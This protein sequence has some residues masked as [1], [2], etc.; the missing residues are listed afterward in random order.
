MVRF[1]VNVSGGLVEMPDV[2][3]IDRDE[4]TEPH[5]LQFIHES[6]RQYTLTGGLASLDFRLSRDVAPNSHT[7]LLGRC[8]TYIELPLPSRTDFPVDHH[9]GKLAWSKLVVDYADRGAMRERVMGAFPFLHYISTYML[10]H[11]GAAFAGKSYAL[12]SLYDFPL[13]DWI[14]VTN[15]TMNRGDYYVPSTSL[16]HLLLEWEY[17]DSILNTGIIQGILERCPTGPVMLQH[18][19]E[20]TRPFQ[21]CIS[22]I[23]IGEDLNNFCGGLH[24][25]PLA[26]VAYGGSNLT[27]AYVQMLLDRGAD[28]NVC[29]GEIDI[30][31]VETKWKIGILLFKEQW[32]GLTSPQ[33][34]YSLITERTSI[35]VVV[36]M[37]A[38]S[39]LL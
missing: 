37:V 17:V 6:V 11:M 27:N 9:T 23:C 25:T 28:P 34:S 18:I 29:N 16:L 5:H 19:D 39:V 33:S 31:Y 2:F 1:I 24:G 38:L 8:L 30:S 14:N 20:S 3:G 13:Q 26:A 4:N 22:K 36:S 7:I 35:A 32:H 21:K 15:I 10:C 12:E